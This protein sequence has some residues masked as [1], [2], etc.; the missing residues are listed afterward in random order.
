MSFY[1]KYRPQSFS[2]LV[3]QDLVRETLISEIKN[4]SLTHAYLFCGPRGTGKTS[5]ARLIAKALNCTNLGETGEPCDK[6]D[7]CVAI[8]DGSL[9]DVL[10]IDAASNR[11]IDEIRD[12]KEKI[13]Y[14]PTQAKNKI[15]IIDEVHMLTKE[16]FNALLKTLEEPPSQ[17]FFILC[18]TEIHKIPETIISRCQRFDFK[19]IDAQSITARLAHIAAEEKIEVEEGALEMI[20]HHVEGGMR[21]AIGLMEQLAIDKKLTT[22]HIRMHLSITGHSTIQKLIDC[23]TAKDTNTALAM[24]ND[25][26]NEGYDMSV[27]IREV[28]EFL[29]E[30]LIESVQKNTGTTAATLQMIYQ[31]EAAREMQ[32]TTLIP[33]LPMEI[34]VIKMCTGVSAPQMAAPQQTQAA[35]APTSQQFS[36]PAPSVRPQVAQSN[37]APSAK[38]MARM[39]LPP[40]PTMPLQKNA[41]AAAPLSIES[42]PLATASEAAT[43][44]A[45]T[46]EMVKLEGT[47]AQ[48][49]QRI[50]EHVSPPS[51]RRSLVQC[52]INERD[53]NTL[54]LAFRAKFHME[55]VNVPTVK[56]SLENAIKHLFDR[57]VKV[58]CELVLMAVPNVEERTPQKIESSY[59]DLPPVADTTSDVAPGATGTNAK[60]G[61][62][63]DKA[64]EMFG[65]W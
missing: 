39:S 43:T 25:V 3:G 20:A 44:Q 9:I 36:A 59:Q 53:D 47:I 57:T 65:E 41:T 64:M 22:K 17:V 40:L 5:S 24:I 23:I 29:R 61:T 13:N 49:W 33:Q 52:S 55:K 19:R 50:I 58:V 37:S 14:A 34:A 42:T 35:P 8:R 38:P 54:Q 4:N 12:L 10:E 31:I 62:A 26:H 15:Y 7:L 16:A 2:S 51:L 30:K 60:S 27:F 45:I 6:C 11:G 46:K 63:A 1:T 18:T 48:H 21:D 32:R 56:S 28:L